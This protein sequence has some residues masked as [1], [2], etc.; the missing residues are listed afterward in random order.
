MS[1]GTQD[2]R[3]VPRRVR[4]EILRRDNN[5]CRYCGAQAPDVPLTVDHVIP[6]ALGGSNDPTNLVTACKDCNAGKTSTSPDERT[7]ADVDA[8]A[9]QWADALTRAA[10][11]R[12]AQLAQN[13]EL[14]EQA[15]AAWEDWSFGGNGTPVPRDRAWRRSIETF[16]S[17]G[18]DIDDIR[19][20]TRVAMEA[21]V[22]ADDTWRYFC[23]CCWKE[24]TRRQ[25]MATALLSAPSE[26]VADGDDYMYTGGFDI[27]Y[28]LGYEEGTQARDDGED[29]EAA[30]DRGFRDGAG[31]LVHYRRDASD[32]D[33]SDMA[34]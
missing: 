17:A 13:D 16:L 19:R 10:E 18:L 28:R 27:G 22:K 12:R 4:F 21:K 26:P 24:V 14:V 20:L 29:A 33:Y 5:T 3:P 15:N 30:Y 11:R 31:R 1:D 23:G 34:E 25:E 32:F 7:V 2:R 8:K 9:M 6:V